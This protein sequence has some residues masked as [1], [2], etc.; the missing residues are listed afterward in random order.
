M[1]KA[2]KIFVD[3]ACHGNPGP[4]GIGVAIF[5]DGA[6]IKEISKPIGEATNNI[7][8]YSALI[9]ALL[10][11]VHLKADRLTILS[12]SQLMCR[13]VGGK[14]KV[15]EPHLKFLHEE[16]LLL[17][18]MFKAVEVCHV[19]REEN[20]LADKL[21]AGSLK[22]KKGSQDDRPEAFLFGEESPSSKG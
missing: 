22:I 9:F 5:Q 13:Q 2:L 3:G 1:S 6:L 14:Y 4:A 8:E 18:K 11:A 17:I 10:E 15:K 12:D 20:A 19:P 21:A 16:I 7:A